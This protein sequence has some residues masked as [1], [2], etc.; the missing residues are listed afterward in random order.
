MEVALRSINLLA[1]VELIR[2][3]TA[4]TEEK[5][6]TILKLFDQHGRFILDNNEFSYVATS[7][8]YLSDVIG[9]FWIGTLMPELANAREWKRFGL[10]EMLREMDKQV[11]NDGAD[12]E[13]STGYHR[14]V[15]EMLLYSFLLAKRDGVGI[16]KKY[17]TKLGQ[18]VGYLNAILR[19]DGRMPLIGDADG[20][21]IVP[22]VKR[23]ADDPRYLLAIGALLFEDPSLA[24]SDL[25]PEVLWLFGEEGVKAFN[26]MKNTADLP[27]SAAFPDAGSYVMRSGDLYLHFNANDCGVN[28]RGSHAHNDALALEVSA[29]GRPFIIDPGSYVYNLD[30][31]ERNMFRSTAYHSTVMIDG[32]EQ[33]TIDRD[34]PF[35]MGNEAKPKVVEWETSPVR[36]K[37]VAEHYG[38]VRLPHSVIHRR[39]VKFNKSERYWLIED[40]LEGKGKHGTCFIFHIAPGV[41][42]FSS[43]HDAVCLSDGAESRLFIVAVGFNG[44]P[45]KMPAFVSRNYGHK[46][47]S[48]TLLWRHMVEIPFVAKF[49]LVPSGPAD[50]DGSRLE[51]ARQ[52]ANGPDV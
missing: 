45:T 31:D 29:F 49:I 20:S 32:I 38:Y 46:Q 28:G 5:F 34:L 44:Q 17:W 30:R 51:L 27:A 21:Q 22:L 9:L 43:A 39:T 24:T 14:F 10:S 48:S 13:S 12:F 7:N 3:S 37:V 16:N 52:I 35:V 41:E 36:D 2:S 50:D 47:E 19:P 33:N 23:D 6:A 11:L 42:I 18:M 40:R 25:T 1:A 8:H 4:I 26:A 15:S